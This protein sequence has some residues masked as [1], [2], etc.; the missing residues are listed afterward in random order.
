MKS[1]EVARRALHVARDVGVQRPLLVVNRMESP[2]DVAEVAQVI[3]DVE[4]VAI[5]EVPTVQQ[6]DR[7][8]IAPLDAAPDSPAVAA[9]AALASRLLSLEPIPAVGR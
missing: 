6:A 3:P 4:L 1:I 7:D 5:P 2:D 9:V 8:G